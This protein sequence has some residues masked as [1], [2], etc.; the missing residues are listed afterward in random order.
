V[1]AFGTLADSFVADIGLAGWGSCRL[2]G[3]LVVEHCLAQR[4]GCSVAEVAVESAVEFVGVVLD[5]TR[6]RGIVAAVA[7]VEIAAEEPN[8]TATTRT[9]AGSVAAAVGFLDQRANSRIAWEHFLA[10][11]VKVV[12]SK[13]VVWWQIAEDTLAGTKTMEIA[14]V[15]MSPPDFDILAIG[16]MGCF[17]N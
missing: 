6:M 5:R 3:P 14:A 2:A 12:V 11:P 1:A 7:G 15:P 13:S 17:G 9:V 4:K 10:H 16:Y 8:Q